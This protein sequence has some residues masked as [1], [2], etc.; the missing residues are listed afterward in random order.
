VASA[1]GPLSMV[2]LRCAL[3]PPYL[4]PPIGLTDRSLRR[5]G[6]GRRVREFIEAVFNERKSTNDPSSGR[7]NLLLVAQ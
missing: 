3:D 6:N 1:S 4:P 5:I 2:R 7:A